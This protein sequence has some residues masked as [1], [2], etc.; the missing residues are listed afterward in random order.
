MKRETGRGISARRKE[1]T[2]F[3]LTVTRVMDANLRLISG[4]QSR[5]ERRMRMA[6]SSART[7]P[8]G[9]DMLLNCLIST[10]LPKSLM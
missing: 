8:N 2:F 1:A 9:P 7:V 4:I 5:R 10:S 3:A 6:R